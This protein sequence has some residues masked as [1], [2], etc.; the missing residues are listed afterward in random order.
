VAAARQTVKVLREQ[1][2]VDA[3]V[4]IGHEHAEAD[5]ALAEAV[6]GIDLIFGSHSHLK[7]DLTRIPG[8]NTWFISPSQYLAYISRV[9]LTFS[10]HKL[11]GVRGAL[12][13]V[14]ARMPEDRVTAARVAE[15][16]ND[17]EHDPQYRQLFVPLGRLAA[18]LTVE[19]LASRTLDAMRK[20]VQ[21]DI[22]LSTVSS[23]RAP[24]AA[25]ELTMEGLRAA[26]PYD[27]EIVVCTMTGAQLQRVL[28]YSASRR[29]TDS[30]S[31][32]SG[33]THPDPAGTY[34]VATTDY[35]ANSAYRDVFACNATRGGLRVRDELRKTF[36]P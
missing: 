4:M 15:M 31:F 14:D 18:P 10:K 36:A 11:T 12:V 1:E 13:P 22:A 5:Y 25:G 34:R 8:T 24:L 26:L 28:D 30:E 21:A 16:Q 23:F 29:G 6:P 17:L 32:V 19:A 35:Q 20:A 2:R 9:Q 3:V 33:D 27:N 7:R